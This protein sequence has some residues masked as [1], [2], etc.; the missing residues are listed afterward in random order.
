MASVADERRRLNVGH[1][2][3]GP[4]YMLAPDGVTFHEYTPRRYDCRQSTQQLL[5]PYIDYL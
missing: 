2:G 4:R 3:V 1:S 5:E